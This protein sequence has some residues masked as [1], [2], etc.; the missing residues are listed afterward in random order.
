MPVFGILSPQKNR[1]RGQKQFYELVP[2]RNKIV[3]D[4][5]KEK[6]KM[7]ETK[8]VTWFTFEIVHKVMIKAATISEAVKQFHEQFPDYD[9]ADLKRVLNDHGHEFPW[10]YS[11]KTRE[12]I[13][14][15][16]GCVYGYTDCIFDSMRKVAKACD[17]QSD[18]T[19][20]KQ[21][22]CDYY[23]PNNDNGCYDNECK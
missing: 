10:V 18:L 12:R 22:I 19:N 8:K 13:Y 9:P 2:R 21:K 20:D 14:Y 3:P 7:K 15:I 16:P 4:H 5:R 23:D 6:K 17:H 1:Q 11:K